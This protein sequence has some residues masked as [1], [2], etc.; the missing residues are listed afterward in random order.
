M[1]EFFLNRSPACVCVSF[2]ELI[3]GDARASAP[4]FCI[5]T[6]T[7]GTIQN[8]G[9]HA[10]VL[11]LLCGVARILHSL[12]SLCGVLIGVKCVCVCAKHKRKWRLKCFQYK[13]GRCGCELFLWSVVG[14]WSTCYSAQFQFSRDVLVCVC[15]CV[16]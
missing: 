2:S 11:R 15:V 16:Y 3:E 13:R 4:P 6:L 10:H 8:G 9:W 7:V 12:V 5:I 1:E 14:V